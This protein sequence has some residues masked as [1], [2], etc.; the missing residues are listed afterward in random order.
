MNRPPHEWVSRPLPG[1]GTVPVRRGSPADA[2]FSVPPGPPGPDH[3][4]L[5][6]LG[7]LLWHRLP[8]A[9]PLLVERVVRELED[10][11]ALDREPRH[12]GAWSV[13]SD[14]LWSPLLRRALEAT[15]QDRT[16]LARYLAVVREAYASGDVEVREALSSYV[17]DG[18]RS[19]LP[20]VAELDRELHD[21][22]V[23]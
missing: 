1:G 6:P 22:V 3:L 9:R 5:G 20:L 11:I 13:V 12:P 21:L 17:L 2:A 10:A 23:G 4:S 15:P 7:D 8:E 19:Y 14:V 16:L 18:L